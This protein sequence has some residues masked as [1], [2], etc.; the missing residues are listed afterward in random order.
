[1]IDRPEALTYQEQP[2]RCGPAA[3]PRRKTDGD[4]GNHQR[5]SERGETDWCL[6]HRVV[7]ACSRGRKPGR[8]L[9]PIACIGRNRDEPRRTQHS[10]VDRDA[11]LKLELSACIRRP[12]DPEVAGRRRDTRSVHENL[13]SRSFGCYLV[14]Q[15]AA[16]FDARDGGR[17]QSF[18]DDRC[19]WIHRRDAV[20]GHVFWLPLERC[21]LARYGKR[22]RTQARCDE[23]GH[24]VLMSDAHTTANAEREDKVNLATRKPRLVGAS[25]QCMIECAGCDR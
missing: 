19:A 14:R 16:T 24:A 15:R 1:M 9:N 25:M 23:E 11:G 8:G 10:E 3:R 21:G 17:I 5:G 7:W 20:H 4:T 12:A 13:E 18:H 22:Q 6:R 2:L